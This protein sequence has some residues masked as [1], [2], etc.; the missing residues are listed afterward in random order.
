MPETS[1][2]EKVAQI[3]VNVETEMFQKYENK[4]KLLLTKWRNLGDKAKLA[5]P[6]Q[7]F[8]SAVKKVIAY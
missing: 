4:N 6:K 7:K 5:E 1:F 3:M 2:K 8:I